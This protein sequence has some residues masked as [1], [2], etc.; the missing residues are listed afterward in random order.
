MVDQAMT[1]V[2][3]DDIAHPMRPVIRG[4]RSDFMQIVDSMVREPTIGDAEFDRS[5]GHSGR[6][7]PA[8]I[9]MAEQ[10]V[11]IAIQDKSAVPAPPFRFPIRQNAAMETSENAV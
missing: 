10:L 6:R 7:P 2:W 3:V 11:A 9:R 5:L 4:H 1:V 8:I